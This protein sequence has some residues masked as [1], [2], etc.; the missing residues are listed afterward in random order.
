MYMELPASSN[1]GKTVMVN[2]QFSVY[3]NGDGIV[4]I[5]IVPSKQ[6][7]DLLLQHL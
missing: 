7:M 3:D 6:A 1:A 4:A 2:A 5:V